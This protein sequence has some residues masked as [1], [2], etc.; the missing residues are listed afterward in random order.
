[1][2]KLHASKQIKYYMYFSY[3]FIQI[4]CVPQLRKPLFTKCSFHL[5]V[6]VFP[7]E[8]GRWGETD[9]RLFIFKTLG[10]IKNQYSHDLLVLKCCHFQYVF[11]F[12]PYPA[13]FLMTVHVCFHQFTVA[14]RP[15]LSGASVQARVEF[16]A[17]SGLSGA[18]I[19]PQNTATADSAVEFIAKPGGQF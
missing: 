1:M 13:R 5:C 12:K 4:P 6:D 11:L 14:G 9:C 3:C 7:V 2:F 8:T 17:S 19:T 18:Q 15:G 16:R 10:Y